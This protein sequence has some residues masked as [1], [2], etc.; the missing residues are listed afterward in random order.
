MLRSLES[1]RTDVNNRQAEIIQ[2]TRSTQTDKCYSGVGQIASVVSACRLHY[3]H[4]PSKPAYE[5]SMEANKKHL[6]V[7]FFPNT[8]AIQMEDTQLDLFIRHMWI[9]TDLLLLVA[10]MLL[11]RGQ[12]KS[13]LGR[14][15]SAKVSFPACH[16]APKM[17]DT[18]DSIPWP[19][20]NAIIIIVD[21]VE[22][23][24]SQVINK[25]KFED[26]KSFFVT[27]KLIRP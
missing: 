27:P 19:S 18:C 15:L 9:Y 10:A 17:M 16:A 6:R 8:A 13:V 7:L 11:W 22:C 21:D 23:R 4:V 2:Q 3:Q 25:N 14:R 26:V 5:H 24:F 20:A 12:G 1:I